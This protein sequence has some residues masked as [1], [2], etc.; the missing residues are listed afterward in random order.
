MTLIKPLA[1]GDKLT[2]ALMQRIIDQ[3]NMID[4]L[5]AGPGIEVKR[6][7]GTIDLLLKEILSGFT[8]PAF[9]VTVTNTGTTDISAY[10]PCGIVES[11][12]KT[13][14]NLL[15]GRSLAVR[16][17]KAQDFGSCI[18]AQNRI[19][20]NGGG[21]KAWIGGICLVRLVRWF[22]S[23]MLNTCDCHAD[24][25]YA[26]A[27]IGGSW[28][29][30]WEETQP[31]TGAA[32]VASDTVNVNEHWAIVQFNGATYFKWMNSGSTTVPAFGAVVSNTGISTGMTAGYI[33]GMSPVDVAANAASFVNLGG[34]VA[35][36]EYGICTNRTAMALENAAVTA[37][38]TV[39]PESSKTTFTTGGS[40]WTQIASLGSF[41]SSEYGIIAPAGGAPSVVYVLNAIQGGSTIWS[42]GANSIS[43][44]KYDAATSILTVPNVDASVPAI[45]TF[46]VGLGRASLVGGGTVYVAV[47]PDPGTGVVTGLV[48]HIPNNSVCLSFTK[49]RIPLVTDSSVLVDVYVPGEF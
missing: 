7:A 28:N 20:A 41:Q 44:I 24:Q 25:K 40:G 4:R 11:I 37:A 26:L 19:L 33:S 6:G 43:G 15:N 27:T 14:V 36:G 23:P 39:G 13:E 30:L 18:I 1:R 35:S 48:S 8:E 9:E 17:P 47:R 16:V 45:G 12:E 42:S 31:G 29:I 5:Q 10:A 32:L 46:A 38:S 2:L 34:S 21:G 49:V 22:D 3:A